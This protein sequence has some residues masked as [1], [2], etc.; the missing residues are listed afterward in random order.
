M[1]PP[2]IIASSSKKLAKIDEDV[3]VASK[4]RKLPYQ[5]QCKELS[6]S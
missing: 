3:N 4:R 2:Q 6:N 5:L 1:T